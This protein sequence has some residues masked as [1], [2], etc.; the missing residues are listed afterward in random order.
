MVRGSRPQAGI[1]GY[2]KSTAVREADRSHAR[3]GCG[4]RG[5][6]TARRS[7]IHDDDFGPRRS[8]LGYRSETDG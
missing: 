5:D 2:T 3:E 7:V 4:S 8:V 1:G 6:G